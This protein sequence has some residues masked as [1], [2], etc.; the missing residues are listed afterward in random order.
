VNSSNLRKG[1][2][3]LGLASC[4][5]RVFAHASTQDDLKQAYQS[6]TVVSVTKIPRPEIMRTMWAF[7][8]MARC[9]S[10][11]TNQQPGTC[12]SPSTIGSMR[13]SAMTLSIHL[14]QINKLKCPW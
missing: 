1:L 14:C 5:L 11:G 9:T 8:L 13:E 4:V 7:A 10:E 2:V 12:P 6:A 3:V